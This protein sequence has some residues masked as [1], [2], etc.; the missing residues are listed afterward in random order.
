MIAAL[1]VSGPFSEKRLRQG[2]RDVL[3]AESG[4]NDGLGFPFVYLTVSVLTNATAGL[5]L[6]LRTTHPHKK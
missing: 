4:A 1:I 6:S 2:F 3:T 5:A